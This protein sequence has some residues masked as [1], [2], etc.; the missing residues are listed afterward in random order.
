MLMSR[1]IKVESEHQSY[2]ENFLLRNICQSL[3]I[4]NHEQRA[5]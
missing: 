5:Q 3:E 1:D 2:L 4:Y